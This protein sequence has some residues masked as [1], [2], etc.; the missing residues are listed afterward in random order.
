MGLYCKDC[1]NELVLRKGEFVCDECDRKW[2]EIILE[3]EEYFNKDIVEKYN[4]I[5]AFEYGVLQEL[6]ASNQIY[7]LMFQIKDIYEIIVRMPVLLTASL[8]I[9]KQEH[10]KEEKDFLWSLMSKPLSF[11]DWRAALSKASAIL[12]ADKSSNPLVRNFVDEVK[13]FAN[14]S[15]QG[16]IVF[17][18]NETIAHGALKLMC[19][20]ELYEDISTRLKMITEFLTKNS[21]YFAEIKLVTTNGTI[22][23]GNK[24]DFT[25]MQGEISLNYQDLN[26][27]LTPFYSVGDGGVYFYDKYITRLHKTDILEY[28]RGKKISLYVP[29][30]SE[31]ASSIEEVETNSLESNSYTIQERELCEKFLATSDYFEPKFITEWLEN[32]IENNNKVMLLQMEEGMGKSTFVRAIDNLSLNLIEL[33]DV[34]VRTFYINST[35][36]SRVDDFSVSVIDSLRKTSQNSTVANNL[37]EIDLL[38]PNTKQAFADVLNHFKKYHYPNQNLLFVFDGIDELNVK[39]ERNITDY[40][41]SADMLDDG[42]FVLVTC[43]TELASDNISNFIRNYIDSLNCEKLKVYES[44]PEY[45]EFA[46]NYFKT[47]VIAKIK[48]LAKRNKISNFEITEDEISTIFNK[49]Q[50]KSILN[51]TFLKEI[52]AFNFE[53]FCSEEKEISNL[54]QIFEDKN[55]YKNYLLGI[56]NTTGNRYYEK[57]IIILCVLA[58]ASKPLSLEELAYL[59]GNEAPNF[60][61]LG[62]VNSMKLFLSAKRT[63][64]GSKFEI[65]HIEQK[66]EICNLF[67]EKCSEYLLEVYEKIMQYVQISKNFI[68]KERSYVALFESIFNYF[69]N[70]G[71]NN[72]SDELFLALIQIK[73]LSIWT[74]EQSEMLAENSTIKRLIDYYDI[75]NFKDDVQVEL[76]MAHLIEV[77]A[78]NYYILNR[79][80]LCDYY[81]TRAINTYKKYENILNDEQKFKFTNALT[82]YA[83]YKLYINENDEGADLYSYSLKFTED[84]FKNKSRNEDG[85]LYYSESY[86]LSEKVCMSNLYRG[87]GKYDKVLEILDDVSKKLPNCEEDNRKY[88]TIPFCYLGYG[89]V[90]D[91]LQNYEEAAKSYLLAIENY[92][93][94]V[95][96]K[97]EFYIPDCILCYVGAI[98]DYLKLNKAEDVEKTINNADLYIKEMQNIN[99]HISYDSLFNYLKVKASAYKTINALEKMQETKEHAIK[100]YNETLSEENKNN[101]ILRNLIQEIRNI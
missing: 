33:C 100:L 61:F 31:I 92:K 8:Y 34:A 29:E 12:K 89:Q 59:S 53:K 43:R 84:L 58:L 51:L 90:Y 40:I 98:N 66:K 13:K 81:F 24:I 75:G 16:D 71:Y 28:L 70:N 45:R 78:L 46:L 74:K 69:E 3:D 35:Y 21:L 57:F 26:I 7:G 5:I 55:I 6:L 4:T 49:I 1:E 79:F 94:C 93:V 23:E 77:L 18:R 11:G 19:D 97:V 101:D 9:K 42:V 25:N 39:P 17:W 50:R 36:N 27:N 22:L 15:K 64:S 76:S 2:S 14:S 82:H 73:Y 60:A 10:T 47:K 30:I 88:R 99:K 96:K 87:C 72:K 20:V 48:T 68:G 80:E 91:L 44:S 85:E 32:N 65:S 52:F 56:K 83:T 41:P 38:N 37:K 54:L 62:F 86:Y 63:F 95:D 67:K